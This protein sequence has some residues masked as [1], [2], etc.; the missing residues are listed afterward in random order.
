MNR[1]G[2]LTSVAAL[3][4]ASG[5]VGTDVGNPQT[6]TPSELE[7]VVP[8]VETTAQALM[9]EGWTIQTLEIYVDSLSAVATGEANPEIV[10]LNGP[11]KIDLVGLPAPLEFEANAET[12]QQLAVSFERES[13]PWL[14]AE[15]IS[16]DGRVIFIEASSTNRIRY[17]GEIPLAEGLLFSTHPV[18]PWLVE[19]ADSLASLAGNSTISETNEPQLLR[20]FLR[21]F[22]PDAKLF[23][24]KDKN[25]KFDEQDL[26][27]GIPIP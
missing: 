19:E 27:V 3:F 7:F 17:K 8:V 10:L 1:P 4:V 15:L 12:V 24:D 2:I 5:C 23:L 22:A 25:S 20:S 13:A 14:E 6:H 11:V 26:N 16:P 9:S 21:A 18:L